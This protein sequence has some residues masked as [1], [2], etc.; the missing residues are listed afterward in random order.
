MSDD[1]TND[2]NAYL[3]DLQ[4]IEREQELAKLRTLSLEFAGVLDFFPKLREELDAFH[5]A[6]GIAFDGL[7][8]RLRPTLKQAA[9]LH[10]ETEHLPAD[11]RNAPEMQAFVQRVK[12]SMGVQVVGLFAAQFQGVCQNIRQRFAREKTE[13]ERQAKEKAEFKRQAR[14]RAEMERKARERVKKIQAATP[15]MVVIPAGTFRMGCVDGWFN[16][17]DNVMGG[18]GDREKPAHPVSV[19]RFAMG[20]YPV[21]FAQFD[22]YCEVTGLAKPVDSGWGRGNRP[23][24]NVSWDDAQN[25]V[26]WLSE[27]TDKVYRLPSE[28]EWEYAARGGNDTTAYPW[29]QSIDTTRANYGKHV[30]KTTPVGQYPA[31]G[32]GLYDMHGNVWEWCQDELHVNYQGAPSTGIVWAGGHSAHRML[33]GGSWLGELVGDCRSAYRFV[34]LPDDHGSYIGFRLALDLGLSRSTIIALGRLALLG[35]DVGKFIGV[36]E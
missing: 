25:Y 32:F 6:E 2:P 29:G 5:Q 24:I 20:K 10:F 15:E 12:Q 14:A 35:G 34:H 26:V 9:D 8:D 30:G 22:A 3:R 16:G 28:A 33:R 18:C 1:F 23:V 7:S 21:T 4:R 19:A 36:T 11:V 13:A 17:R 27:V 31:N